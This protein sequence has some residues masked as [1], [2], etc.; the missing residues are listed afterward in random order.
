MRVA[1]RADASLQIGTG[2]VMRCLT[3]AHRLRVLGHE[4][5]FL[6]RKHE[7]NLI[8]YVRDEGFHVYEMAIGGS[9]ESSIDAS[10]A[11]S[12][13]LGVSQEED[14]TQSAAFLREWKP[15]WLLVDHY[16]LDH[17]WEERTGKHCARLLVIDD[18]VDR[19]HLCD[20][21]LDQTLGHVAADYQNLTP[22]ECHVFA[23]PEFA[24]LRPEFSNLRPY[25][26]T[27]RASP[28][29]GQILIS[30]GGVDQQN[31]TTVVLETLRASRLDQRCRVVVV[32]GPTAPWLD[33]VCAMAATMPFSTQVLAG[34]RDM[35]NQMA[36]CDLAIGAAGST[37]W[38]RCCLGVPTLMVVLA[39]N[40]RPSA[41]ALSR[42]GAAIL[43]GDV[44]EIAG[45]LPQALASVTS[46]GTLHRMSQAAANVCDG[47]G[48]H[49]VASFMETMS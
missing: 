1:F 15:D 47:L 22:A 6:T 24:L 21:L 29:I 25:S 23:G 43:L 36:N 28:E 37:S 19:R 49:R 40:Q 32:L 16:G 35:A 41:A 26:L 12:S 8:S 13:W 27:R 14:A 33:Q 31:A 11:H 7:G 9:G 38:E 3:L 39:D 34:V 10:L 46:V 5:A 2:H 44:P 42:H 18:L 20:A 4:C 17:R 45:R 30:M 48:A